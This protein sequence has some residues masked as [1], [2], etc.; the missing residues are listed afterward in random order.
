MLAGLP[1]PGGGTDRARL[2]T[3]GAPL[4]GAYAGAVGAAAD[5]ATAPLTALHD[6]VER[7]PFLTG[8]RITDL[9]LADEGTLFV[10]AASGGVWR[11]DDEGHTLQPAWPSDDVHAVG[12]LAITADGTLLAGTGEANAGGGS[13][14]FTG[15]GVR[16]STDGGTTWERSGLP[17][18]GTIARL[19]AHPTDPDVVFAAAGGDLFTPGG[20]R[21]IFRS[22][23]GGRTWAAV[24]TD[25]PT[26]GGADLAM[27]PTDPDHLLATMWDRQRTPDLR[28][29]GGPG[30]GL[31][32]S[33]D[34]GDTW[35]PVTDGIPGFAADSGRIAV[36]FSPADPSRVYAVV[37]RGDG[38]SGGFHRS[39]D[40][41]VTWALVN[42]RDRY[43][44]SQFIFGWWFSK[45]FPAPEDPD[46]VLVPGLQLLES[47]DGGETFVA[48]A[49]VHAD[50]HA[51]VW[52][53][54][55]PSVAHL[56]SDGGLYTSRDGG[57]TFSWTAATSQPFTQAYT[58]AVPPAAPDRVVAGFQ[59]IG[60]R[61]G[62]AAGGWLRVGGCGDGLVALPHPTNPD[63][64]IICGQYARCRR[65]DTFDARTTN[66]P[67]ADVDR[68]GW[69]APLVRV[70]S[71][72][73]HLLFGGNSLHRSNDG[74]Q[75]W[76]AL[77]GDLT[78]G[79][80]PDQDYPFG[81]I[82]EIAVVDDA[83]QQV[84]VGT[85]DGLLW[86]TTDGGGTWGRWLDGPSWITGIVAT[87]DTV[88][89]ATSGYFAGTRTAQL[90]RTT[91]GGTTWEPISDGLP[92][93]PLNDVIRAGAATVVASDVGA[94]VSW[95]AMTAQQ[96]TWRRVGQGLPQAPVLDLDYVDGSQL[97]TVATFG[98][99][100]WQIRLPVLDRA[101]GPD[102]YATAV[103]VGTTAGEG[104]VE[105]V[106][107][108]SGENF[109]D[110]L[111][112]AALVAR[113]P[114]WRLLLTAG[115]SLPGAT[116]AALGA[117]A[118]EALVVVGGTGAVTDAV[119]T[120]AADA[121]GT[122]QV[123]RLAG[124]DRYATAAAVA[125]AAPPGQEV[126]LAT[127]G[128][129]F[130]AL[131][132]AALAVARDAVVLLVD[133]E[134]VPIAT[135]DAL[136]ALAPTRITAIGGT[137]AISD[138]ALGEA[139]AAAGGAVTSRIA[140]AG[141]VATS[142]AV[143]SAAV[144]E[145][146]PADAVW[147]A[148]AAAASDA[149]VAAATGQP[150]LL[151]GAAALSAETAEALAMLAPLRITLAGG[152]AALGQSLETGLREGVESAGSGSGE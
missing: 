60:C 104:P 45:V 36:A 69:G 18:S 26:T 73:D 80:S 125:T 9:A 34:G 134:S 68:A 88:V 105:T 71:D 32:R 70:P 82:S 14:T 29:Y 41:G 94:F 141:R 49:R 117:T 13:T 12:A 122:S 99:G 21:G 83:G 123:G 103:E 149:L 76:T 40:G 42:D 77:S 87:D 81:T 128:T 133:P 66:V 145:G 7:G 15:D 92:D 52:A 28:R 100:I 113:Q 143:A 51:L 19:V 8:G 135:A 137:S 144:D 30:S 85:D 119:M 65:T 38:R 139:G 127:A 47:T 114:G 95:D 20:E 150:V 27:D 44:A 25:N 67:T 151:T 129:P 138:A 142:V 107:L 121:A 96:P 5:V 53:D 10:A 2:P 79:S 98:R 89:A 55:D 140:G 152:P 126:L 11:S 106:V 31:Y 118:P 78:R 97:L 22:T 112:A 54:G 35:A 91:D 109:P 132:A 39:D 62:D 146:L 90:R 61:L 101:A 48:D 57:R 1:E 37:T 63:E 3:N 23:D 148:S 33:T 131:S 64:V 56:G 102:R 120:A 17:A 147:L 110:A 46:R 124:P 75:T 50:Q 6:W 116:A 136:G 111:A 43:T 130:D 24:L 93:A 84:L 86:G 72:P 74:G 16:R 115:T 108:A 4:V 59:D 58:V